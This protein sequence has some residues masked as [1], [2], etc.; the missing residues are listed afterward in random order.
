MIAA[1]ASLG[2]PQPLQRAQQERQG[3]LAEKLTVLFPCKNEERNIGECIAS[4]RDIADE[5]LLADSGSTDGTMEIARRMGARIIEREYEHHL[6]FRNWAVPQAANP[7]VLVLDADERATPELAAEI[8]GVLSA[9]PESDGYR[10]HRRGYFFGRE[11]KHCGWSSDNV[12]RLFRRDLAR[13]EGPRAHADVVIETGKVGWLGGKLKHF[14]YWTFDQ[15]FEKFGRYSTWSAQDLWDK[16]RRAGVFSLTVRPA[17][18]FF[19]QYVLR[20]GFLDGLPGLVLCGLAAMSVF[21]KYAKLWDLQRRA[22]RGEYPARGEGAEQR[23]EGGE[24]RP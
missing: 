9:K 4:V 6:S 20:L 23:A 16:G 22:A 21:T 11:I 19:R 24:A 17:F 5:L 14:T 12:L 13:Y 2:A 8:K 7:W 3:A 1:R 10:I 15:Y 18:R